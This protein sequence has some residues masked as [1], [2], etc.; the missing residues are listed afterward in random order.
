M[1]TK[2]ITA[3]RTNQNDNVEVGKIAEATRTMLYQVFGAWDAEKAVDWNDVYNCVFE[4]QKT[5]KYK[6]KTQ[7][8]SKHFE[9]AAH[10]HFAGEKIWSQLSGRPDSTYAGLEECWI[11][12]NSSRARVSDYVESVK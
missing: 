10:I 3:P 7:N 11:R 4:R 1:G 5:R 12:V 2:F 6:S 8:T 9:N